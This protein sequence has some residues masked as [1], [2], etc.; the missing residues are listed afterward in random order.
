MPALLVT[1]DVAVGLG[2][3]GWA[4]GLLGGAVL[5]AL[6][7][8][9]LVRHRAGGLGPAGRITATRAVL[10]CGVAALTAESYVADDHAALIVALATVGLVLD[11]VDGRVARRTRTESALGGRFDMEVDAFLIAVL[12][13]YVAPAAGWW[14]LAIGAIRYA[15]VAVSWVVRWLRRPLPPR[16]SAKV[17]AALQ[18][19]VLTVAAS[20]LV[21]LVVTQA[22]LVV[23]LGLLVESFARDVRTLWRERVE[24]LPPPPDPAPVG[25]LVRPAVVTAAAFVGLWVALALPNPATGL[26]PADLLRIPL[27]GLVLVAVALVLPHRPRFWAAVGFGAVAGALLVLRVV[28]A[29]F[30]LVLD[31]PFDPLGDWGYFASGVDVLGDSIGDLA[32]R[33]AAVGVVVLIA[34]V[35]VGLAG[36]AAR[37]VRVAADHRPRATRGVVALGTAWAVCAIAG[38][39]VAGGAPVAAAGAAGLA[40]DTVDQVRAGLADSD[41]FAEEIEADPFADV[42]DDQLLRGLRGK[43]VLLVFVESYGRS[44]TR[45]SSYSPGVEEVL[46]DG[47]RRLTEAGYLTRSGYLTSPTFGAASWLAHATTQSGLW[48]D[49]ERRYGQLLDSD[50]L[51]LA[52]AFGRAGWRTVFDVPANT[53]D[54]PEGEA[55]YGFD[56]IYDSRNVGYAGPEFGY[57]LVPDQYTLEHLRREELTGGDR[58]PLFAEVDLVS[59]HHPWT[60]PPPLVAWDEVGDGSVFEGTTEDAEPVDQE[61]DPAKAQQLYGRSIEYSWE[62]LVSFLETYPD[63]DRVVVVLGDHEPWSFV[64]GDDAGRDVPITVI[65]QDGD[66]VRR[67]ADWQWSP[68]LLPPAD[69]PVWPMSELRDRLLTAFAGG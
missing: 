25:S 14:V 21:P 51:T 52:R 12:S 33:L 10:A 17:V 35:I 16:Y 36:A 54:W 47:T 4:I 29:G 68:G 69:A 62:T 65:A 60:P 55:F 3:P 6:L 45:G 31:R 64:S 44:A 38:I 43:D 22:V 46:V 30:D 53:E 5:A 56:H 20:A 28:N 23:A 40:V 2:P 15:Y 39:H 42:P 66:V 11:A 26:T 13:V 57:A 63:P 9:A 37:V 32:A 59:S 18:G 24:P 27:E 1:L 8:G 50:R 34:V 67:T 48:V 58:P 61:A 19:I 49:S 7:D 41:D